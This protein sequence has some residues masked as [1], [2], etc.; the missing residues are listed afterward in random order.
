MFEMETA[1]KSAAICE[2][3]SSAALIAL[4]YLL[5]KF[6]IM[7]VRDVQLHSPDRRK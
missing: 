2:A 1:A 5:G 7:I 6:P 4:D 3:A